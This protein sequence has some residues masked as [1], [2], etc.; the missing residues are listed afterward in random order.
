M[1]NQV[2]VRVENIQQNLK[3]VDNIFKC[4]RTYWGGENADAIQELYSLLQKDIFKST[5]YL[6]DIIKQIGYD[7]IK[8]LPGD[9]L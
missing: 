8:R 3:L 9:I 4:M 1:K 6:E 2:L 5:E 7:E